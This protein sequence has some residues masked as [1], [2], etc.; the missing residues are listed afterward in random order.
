ME[1]LLRRRLVCFVLY[2]ALLIASFYPQSL[3]PRDTIAYVGDSLYC[4]YVVGWLNQQILNDPLHWYQANILYPNRSTLT[5]GDHQFLPSLLVGPVFWPTDN[6]VLAYNVSVAIACMLAAFALRHLAMR[7]GVGPVGAWT[8][9]ALYAFHTYQ[10]NE[11]PRLMILYHGFIP[12]ALAELLGFLDDGASRRAW[13]LA[14]L[15]LLQAL[16]SSYH[17]AY[18]SLLIGLIVLL[19]LLAKPAATWKKLP[20]LAAASAVAAVLYVPFIFPYVR[21]AIEYRYSRE[22]PRGIDLAHYFSTSPTNVWY[23]AIGVEARLQ[24]QGPHFIGFITIAC[25][26]VALGIWVS[27]NRQELRNALLPPSIWVPASAVF[28]VLFISLSLGRDVVAFGKTIGPGPYRVL[29][30]YAPGFQLIRV[31]ERLAL[32]AMLFVALLVGAA[33]TYVRALGFR[34][35]AL[36]LAVLVPLEHLSPLPVTDR[37]PV[38]REVPAV[39][40]WL[41]QDRARAI[42][43]VP[44]HGEALVRK[45]TLEMYFSTRHLKPIVHGYTAYPPL[46][47]S[48]MRRLAEQFPEDV[49]IHGLSKAG[50]DTVVVHHGRPRAE[51]IYGRLQ[52]RVDAGLLELVAR[53]AGAPARVYQGTVDE[54]YRVVSSPDLQPAPRP[55]GRR[56]IDPSWSY[57]TKAG[58]P[59]LAADGDVSTT[60]EVRRAL[61]GDEFFEVTFDRPIRVSGVLMRLRQD[62]IFPTRFKIGARRPD[63]EWVPLAFYDAAHQMQLLEQLLR[64]PLDPQLGFDWADRDLAGIR[65]MLDEGGHS[66]LGWSIPEIEVLVPE[67]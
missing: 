43:E 60:W 26:L 10:V 56:R 30:Q 63:G 54:V 29:F 3:R 1:D 11:A 14:G 27:G 16:A 22:L 61:A 6:P 41:K 37:I 23:G 36:L 67:T 44:I 13:R 7:L 59:R 47:A 55:R 28:A 57:R 42:V 53:F 33:L 52:A 49:S 58:D 21:N 48:V 40:E 18:G 17:L 15:M 5:F 19:F 39:Y 65:I 4:V 51:A 20:R 24:Q 8:A 64:D 34:T 25:A 46:L 31:P 62:S 32:I 38:G 9:G 35:P 50:V 12:L 45:E 2:G 66:A